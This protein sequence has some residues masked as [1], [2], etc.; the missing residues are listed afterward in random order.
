MK[1][2]NKF[3][4]SD[5]LFWESD[6]H[7]WFNNKSTTTYAQIKNSQGISLKLTSF[8][9]RNKETGDYNYVLMDNETNELIYDSTSL[10]KLGVHIDMMKAIKTFS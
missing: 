9:V 2:R 6:T 5:G 3:I 1:E 4:E 7:E 8:V 10:E